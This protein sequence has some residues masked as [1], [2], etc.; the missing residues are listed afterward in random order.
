MS[1]YQPEL[2]QENHHDKTTSRFIAV[3]AGCASLLLVLLCIGLVALGW[4][5]YIYPTT[6]TYLLSKAAVDFN[7]GQYDD[8]IAAYQNVLDQDSSNTEALDGLAATAIRMQQ[9]GDLDKAVELYELI[10]QINPDYAGTVQ[11]NRIEI[12]LARAEERRANNQMDEAVSDLTAVLALDDS[13][14]EANTGLGHLYAQR[15]M[16]GTAIPYYQA[17]L[18][19]NNDAN[20]ARLGLAWAYYHE[21]QYE[22]AISEFQRITGAHPLDSAK[23]QGLSYLALQQYENALEPHLRQWG[24]LS[25]HDPEPLASIA[26]SYQGMGDYREA[27]N[28]Y[29]Q[30]IAI[31]SNKS[32]YFY[33]LGQSLRQLEEY[34]QAIVAYQSAIAINNGIPAYHFRLGT[35]FFQLADHRQAI[36]AFEQ[37]LALD[38]QNVEYIIEIARSYQA[39]S[40]HRQAAD[41]YQQATIIR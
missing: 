41:Y 18:N 4:Y 35:L 9:M 2:Q 32:S 29:R 28:Y 22:S 30:A 40:D 36:G 7:A 8:A 33:G 16:Y 21:G 20:D 27:A 14:V 37:A 10:E 5:Y 23:G 13:H 3:A 11:A 17:A 1:A 15:E 34:E 31:D 19:A 26:R 25:P 39:L 38:P 6:S 24:Q 12:L